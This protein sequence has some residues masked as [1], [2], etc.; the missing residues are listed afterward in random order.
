MEIPHFS[1]EDHMAG[2]KKNTAKGLIK[3]AVAKNKPDNK[4]G[5]SF[6]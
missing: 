2:R 6:L 3:S 4:K 1:K 5:M